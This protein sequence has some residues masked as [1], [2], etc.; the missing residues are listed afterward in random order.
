MVMAVLARATGSPQGLREVLMSGIA[1]QPDD[2]AGAAIDKMI[3]EGG[4]DTLPPRTRG[5][6]TRTV[7]THCGALSAGPTARCRR[8][9]LRNE[10]SPD[11][12][13]SAEIRAAE[14]AAARR[15]FR[16]YCFACGRSSEAMSAP[17]NPGRCPACG[18][19]LLV[20]WAGD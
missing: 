11:A 4:P 15:V 14:R 7:C 5:T 16:V 8:C 18:G 9:G 6:R 17:T 20:E 1:V 12:E 13:R 10:L 2:E 3:D 19:S